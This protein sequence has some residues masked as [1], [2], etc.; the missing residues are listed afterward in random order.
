M[1]YVE[2]PYM[3]CAKCMAPIVKY[4]Y[5]KRFGGIKNKKKEYKNEY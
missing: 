5:C 2:C 1:M 4:E 3:S